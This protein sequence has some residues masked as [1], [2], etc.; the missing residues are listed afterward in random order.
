MVVL[1]THGA[2]GASAGE[3]LGIS[4]GRCDAI[5]EAC[6]HGAYL[7][8]LGCNG[9][10]TF[11]GGRFGALVDELRLPQVPISPC[12]TISPFA[13]RCLRTGASGILAH[14]D[15]TWSNAFVDA[16]AIEAWVDWVA[17]GDGA[18]AFAAEDISRESGKAAI[19]AVQKQGRADPEASLSW[20]RFMDLR[21]F[22]L[23]GD[24]SSCGLWDRGKG[25]P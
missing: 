14:V 2:D 3:P 12:D 25:A 24:P 18:L 19:E 8:H 10:G 6:R 9:A 7:L 20:L 13:L 11:A 5:V 15:S 23:L 1:L 17:S 16:R 22:V 4:R 21:G